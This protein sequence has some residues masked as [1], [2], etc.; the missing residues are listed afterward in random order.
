LEN[1]GQL[2]TKWFNI[3][4]E[5]GKAHSPMVKLPITHHDLSLEIVKPLY[6]LTKEIIEAIEIVIKNE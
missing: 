5:A 4:N 1:I 6:Q 3:I 2:Y